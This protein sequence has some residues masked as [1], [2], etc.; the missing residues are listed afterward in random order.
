MAKTAATIN[1]GVNVPAA[2]IRKAEQQLQSL[3]NRTQSFNKNPIVAKNFTQPLGRITGAANEFNKSLEASNARVIA[4][5]ASAGAIFAVQK[6]LQ[7]LVA[8]TIKVEQRLT[9]IR[10]L[11]DVNGKEF[12]KFTNGLYKVARVTGSTFDQTSESM[13]EFARQGLNVEQSLKRTTAAMTLARLGGMDAKNATES[14]TAA[15]NTFGAAAGSA[16]TIVNKMAQVDA[17]FA[18]SSGDLAEA[19]KRTGA[20]AV[21]SSVSFEELIS[22]VTTAQEKTARGGAVIGNS[23]KTI[24]T[25]I[26]RPETLRQLQAL[27]VGIKS[28]SGEMLPAMAILK[29]YAK[30][31][32]QLSP[33]L[34]ATSSEMLAGV[35]QVNVLKSVLPDL[36]SATGRYD[37]ALRV[38]NQTTNEATRQVSDTNQHN[39]RHIKCYYG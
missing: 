21:S 3:F 30:V 32:G 5:G 36:A 20:A 12:E 24:F 7:S 9:N 27:G 29:N 38:A 33:T 39:R 17:K 22:V 1:I 31:Y 10:V 19:I 15:M 13:E 4:F 23:F 6:A 18:V 37:K 11:L 14:L 8:T 34:K 35:F 25:R 28:A 26:Q 16:T 2:E